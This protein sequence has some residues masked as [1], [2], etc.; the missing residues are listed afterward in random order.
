MNML[1]GPILQGQITTL[2][3]AP[4]ILAY[5]ALSFGHLGSP[6][7]GVQYVVVHSKYEFIRWKPSILSSTLCNGFNIETWNLAGTDAHNC[8]PFFFF[9]TL[10]Y[11]LPNN[12]RL[13]VPPGPS[14][15]TVIPRNSE[16]QKSWKVLE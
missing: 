9:L 8:I 1:I 16:I 7:I 3:N 15:R 4:V 10:N 2:Y 14:N 6:M 12:W 11:E 13:G 5:N